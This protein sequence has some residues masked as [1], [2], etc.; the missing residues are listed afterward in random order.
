VDNSEEAGERSYPRH[1][2][3]ANWPW[4]LIASASKRPER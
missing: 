2:E 4:T 1:V 3:K